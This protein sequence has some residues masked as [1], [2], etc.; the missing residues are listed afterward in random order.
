MGHGVGIELPCYRI[1]RRP[2]LVTGWVLLR[3]YQTHTEAIEAMHEEHAKYGGQVR[4]IV[5]HV[6]E[7]VGLGA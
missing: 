5:Q 6:I 3:S 1:E 4:V 7:I 2:N